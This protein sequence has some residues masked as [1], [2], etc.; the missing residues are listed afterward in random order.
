MP[1]AKIST[2]GCCV[3]N[4]NHYY[5]LQCKV[6]NSSDPI[7]PPARATPSDLSSEELSP[8]Y[9]CN[10]RCRSQPTTRNRRHP[11]FCYPNY[12]SIAVSLVSSRADKRSLTELS[13]LCQ[14]R[15]STSPGMELTK[16]FLRH[17]KY[18]RATPLFPAQRCQHLTVLKAIAIHHSC[19]TC[20]PLSLSLSPFKV[21]RCAHHV[22]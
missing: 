8:V 17:M 4:H 2:G 13:L 16:R 19:L 15:E 10:N 12:Y 3:F 20:V 18:H 9:N 7:Y 21:E 5:T 6:G 11:G 14:N 22:P 1:A